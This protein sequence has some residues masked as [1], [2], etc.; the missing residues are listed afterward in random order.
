MFVADGSERDDRWPG[1]EAEA[2]RDGR[3]G[4]TEGA[5]EKRSGAW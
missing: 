4:K 2:R 1:V 3:H 5:D